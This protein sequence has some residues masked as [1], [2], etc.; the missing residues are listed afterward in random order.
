MFTISIRGKFPFSH[1]TTHY[2]TQRHNSHSLNNSVCISEAALP[3]YR[4]QG[5]SDGR[6]VD[7]GLLQSVEQ[8]PDPLP[9]L[10]LLD[11]QHLSLVRQSWEDWWPPVV[12]E[13]SLKFV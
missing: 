6:Q 3:E 10:L 2:R 11:G 7:Q 4:Q 9:E 12:R 13:R 1:H 8:P 5:E